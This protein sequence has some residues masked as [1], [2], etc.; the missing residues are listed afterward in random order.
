V[1]ANEPI[2]WVWLDEPPERVLCQ[3][4]VHD[5]NVIGALV[6]NRIDFSVTE[7]DRTDVCAVTSDVPMCVITMPEGFMKGFVG[8][9]RANHLTGRYRKSGTEQEYRF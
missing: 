5:I 8:C 4:G 2:W 1:D 3:R 7:T 6:C 9:M